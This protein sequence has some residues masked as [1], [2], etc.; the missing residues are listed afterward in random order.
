TILASI[1]S[2]VPANVTW[3]PLRASASATASDGSTWPAVPPAAMRHRSSRCSCIRAGDVKEDAD[4]Q[5][6]DNERRTA[7]GD[8]REWDPG[9]RREAENGREVDDR[10]AADERDEPR[11]ETL[12][13]RVLARQSDPQPSVGE[14]GDRRDH[15]GHADETELLADDGE[16]HVRVRLGQVVDLSDPLTEADA[17]HAA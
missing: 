6:R 15:P 17:E 8:E 9:Q 2:G 13:E 12:A 11:P 3:T 7:V 4:G 16:D 5:Q 1:R 14:D 10:L